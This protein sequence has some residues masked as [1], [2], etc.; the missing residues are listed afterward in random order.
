MQGYSPKDIV[1]YTVL[2]T[3]SSQRIEM[4]IN[5]NM[6]VVMNNIANNIDKIP[7]A[8]YTKFKTDYDAFV[9][10]STEKQ[11]EIIGKYQADIASGLIGDKFFSAIFSGAVKGTATNVITSGT[12]EIVEEAGTL[13]KIATEVVEETGKAIEGGVD[14]LGIVESRINIANG[15]TRFSPSNKA[16]LEHVLDRHFNLGKN[17]GQFTIS[18]DELKTILGNKDVIKSPVKVLE[19][20]GQYSRTVNV[21]EVVG[22]IKQSIPDVGGKTTTWIEIITDSKGNLITTY[23]CPAPK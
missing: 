12:K 5:I 16:G 19:T 15:P 23:P 7:S 9:T 8:V 17:A 18:V 14:S 11:N 13:N 20:S 6:A 21:G 2:P 22:T 3:N 4:N 10:G 1:K